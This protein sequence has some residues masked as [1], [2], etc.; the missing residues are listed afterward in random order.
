MKITSKT[1]YPC[2]QNF[3]KPISTLNLFPEDQQRSWTKC[4][5]TFSCDEKVPCCS[6]PGTIR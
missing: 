3:K 1:M 6:W 2:F 4:A 5:D